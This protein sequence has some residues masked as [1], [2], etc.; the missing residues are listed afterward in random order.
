MGDRANKTLTKSARQAETMMTS[1]A[2]QVD[3]TLLTLGVEKFKEARVVYRLD[4]ELLTA[5]AE[6]DLKIVPPQDSVTHL[7][8]AYFVVTFGE[9]MEIYDDED[10][11]IRRFTGVMVHGVPDPQSDVLGR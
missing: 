8:H 2:A 9:P 1:L 6:T 3:S 7:P 5:L 11:L 4:P 10:D